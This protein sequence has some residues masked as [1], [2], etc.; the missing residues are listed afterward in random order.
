MTEETSSE[1]IGNVA[2][3]PSGEVTGQPESTTGG[4]GGT[5]RAASAPAD[6]TAETAAQPGEDPGLASGG[7]VKPDPV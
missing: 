4:E 6:L 1:P 7:P 3:K 5:A 2:G